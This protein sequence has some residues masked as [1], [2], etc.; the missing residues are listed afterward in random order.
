M[1][2]PIPPAAIEPSQQKLY[3]ALKE[4][5]P[6]IASMYMGGVSAFAQT[7]LPDRLPMAAHC[8]REFMEKIPRIADVPIQQHSGELH[9]RLQD[10]T[11]AWETMCTT[12]KCKQNG[13]WDGPIDPPLRKMLKRL[14]KS[15]VWYRAAGA[16]RTYEITATFRRLDASGGKLPP[17]IE[18]AHIDQWK[19][20]Q[21]FFI[22]VAHHNQNCT[23]DEFRDTLREVEVFLL[24][25][26]RP[27]PFADQD[28][29]DRLIGG[30]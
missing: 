23:D 24:D 28:E 4:R 12:T 15:F 29:I 3:Q 8:I 27:T 2:D 10:I 22:K 5:D 1:P 14:D 19:E 17:G 18:N 26:M 6:N 16:G 21:R 9:S 7:G 20:W 13:K 30:K 25:R 11:K